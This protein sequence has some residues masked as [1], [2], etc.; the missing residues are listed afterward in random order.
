M[1][2]KPCPLCG[3]ENPKEEWSSA[4]EIRGD[5]WQDGYIECVKPFCLHTVEISINSDKMNGSPLLID[6]WNKSCED[7]YKR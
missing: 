5:S 6:L 3:T 1:K 4:A 2:I 7:I